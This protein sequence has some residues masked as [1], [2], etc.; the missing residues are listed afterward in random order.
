VALRWLDVRAPAACAAIVAVILLAG[1][2]RD[3]SAPY[4]TLLWLATVIVGGGAIG[5][6]LMALM[7]EGDPDAEE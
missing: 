2:F 4:A 1:H 7:M 5:W 6:W 3:S